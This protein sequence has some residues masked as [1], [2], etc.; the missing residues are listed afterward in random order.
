MPPG[1]RAGA[2]KQR[3]LRQ[4]PGGPLLPVLWHCLGYVESP[5]S[6]TSAALP[7]G[8]SEEIPSAPQNANDRSHPPPHDVVWDAVPHP[9]SRPEGSSLGILPSQGSLTDTGGPKRSSDT[10]RYWEIIHTFE[11]LP[12]NTFPE[13]HLLLE[14]KHT[15]LFTHKNVGRTF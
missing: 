5:P 4:A 15:I 9:R 6:A 8:W 3:M 1:C 13:T 2:R 7:P 12:T 14:E 11:V 10:T